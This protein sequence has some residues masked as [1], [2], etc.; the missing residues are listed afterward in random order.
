MGD[1]EWQ[2]VRPVKGGKAKGGKP[3][4]GGKKKKGKGKKDNEDSGPRPL[5]PGVFG[6][7]EM[8]M[9]Q[10]RQ[11]KAD[12]KRA[13]KEAKQAEKEE[14]RKKQR[15][16]QARAEAK[17]QRHSSSSSSSRKAM[18]WDKAVAAMDAD[19]IKAALQSAK[20]DFPNHPPVHMKHLMD[21]IIIALDNGSSSC[22]Q[23]VNPIKRCPDGVV[24]V[25]L[26]EADQHGTDVLRS[27]LA[28]VLKT[29]ITNNIHGD[30]ILAYQ[31]LVQLFIRFETERRL[32]SS[33]LYSAYKA[34]A[35]EFSKQYPNKAVVMPL[36]WTFNQIPT[37]LSATFI[38]VWRVLMLPLMLDKKTAPDVKAACVVGMDRLLPQNHDV[39]MARIK[40]LVRRSTPGVE[41]DASRTIMLI[42]AAFSSKLAFKQQGSLRR[43]YRYLRNLALGSHDGCKKLVAKLPTAAAN[44]PPSESALQQELLDLAAIAFSMQ[45]KYC[46]NALIDG[47]QKP[48]GVAVFLKFL[49]ASKRIPEQRSRADFISAISS[50]RSAAEQ[51]AASDAHKE[52]AA[53]CK[54]VLQQIDERKKQEQQLNSVDVVSWVLLVLMS[55]CFGLLILL[56]SYTYCESYPTQDSRPLPLHHYCERLQEWGVHDQMQRVLDLTLPLGRQLEP[57]ILEGI[58]Q[59]K[60]HWPVVK[61]HAEATYEQILPYITAA[62]EDAV[63]HIVHALAVVGDVYFPLMHT[64]MQVLEK[65]IDQGMTAVAAAAQ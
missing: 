6:Q 29:L 46:V 35:D 7:A 32:Q 33:L 26:A 14:E 10:R 64:A 58:A 20:L 2:E 12:K 37:A 16:A 38:M 8:I 44:T 21:A 30:H 23:Q 34:V 9:E 24:D 55:L 49:V 63:P 62:H 25:F 5:Q 61:H 60:D 31:L 48:A 42:T 54:D 57:H 52:V 27:C 50:L 56:G 18:S 15:E 3:Q 13:K 59:V 11:A 65:W 45:P 47:L 43:Q 22:T 19:A 51:N 1:S 4:G 39:C 28:I 17:R 41:F 53:L 40:V 36:L